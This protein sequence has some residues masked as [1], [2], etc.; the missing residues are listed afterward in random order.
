MSLWRSFVATE[1]VSLL[2]LVRRIGTDTGYAGC[3]RVE[4]TVYCEEQ[5]TQSARE[6]VSTRRAV[7]N[8]LVKV[9]KKWDIRIVEYPLFNQSN[10]RGRDS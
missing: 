4:R 2:G 10:Y 8:Q 1:L 7:V 6:T 3:R 5:T 9:K